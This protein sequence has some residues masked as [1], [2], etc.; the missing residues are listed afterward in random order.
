VIAFPKTQTASCP[1]TS[2]PAPVSKLQLD[3]LN[4]RLKH[5]P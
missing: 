1:L 3:E 2:A 5:M 4:I